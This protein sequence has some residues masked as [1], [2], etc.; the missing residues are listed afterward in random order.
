MS[1]IERR[2]IE[3]ERRQLR[4]AT[5]Q[6]QTYDLLAKVS[7]ETHQHW[8]NTYPAEPVQSEQQYVDSATFK[9]NYIKFGYCGDL[10]YDAPVNQGDMTCVL[11]QNFPNPFGSHQDL[12]FQEHVMPKFVDPVTGSVSYKKDL[13][14][15]PDIRFHCL[16]NPSRTIEISLLYDNFML[17]AYTFLGAVSADTGNEG[18]PRWFLAGTTADYTPIYLLVGK[19]IGY[20]EKNDFRYS[21]SFSFTVKW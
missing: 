8:W 4:S 12:L 6:Q 18:P 19:D 11:N 2:I 17:G 3:L 14:L 9:L 13:Q 7:Q 10:L 20:F 1:D 21:S 15:T 5:A 16:V